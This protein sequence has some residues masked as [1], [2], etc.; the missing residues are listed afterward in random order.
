ML[1]MCVTEFCAPWRAQFVAIVTRYCDEG[2]DINC[3]ANMRTALLERPVRGVSA[4]VCAIDEKKNNLKVNKIDRFSK[5]HNFTYDDKGRLVWRAYD[6][7]GKTNSF[8]WRS[9]RAVRGNWAYCPR[10]W[11]LFYHE[12]CTPPACQHPRDQWHGRTEWRRPPVWMSR[13]WMSRGFQ[14]LLWL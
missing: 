10:E 13:T 9:C 6:G 11:R 14:E 2:H 8:W 4:S 3:A 7:T 5:L 1:R 12:K